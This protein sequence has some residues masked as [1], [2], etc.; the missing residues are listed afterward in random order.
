MVRTRRALETRRLAIIVRY[1]T[2]KILIGFKMTYL[3]DSLFTE[4]KSSSD[5]EAANVRLSHGCFLVECSDDEAVSS[6]KMTFLGK[7]SHFVSQPSR[8][9]TTPLICDGALR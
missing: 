9:P 5:E 7:S 3:K 2:Q 6:I 8:L 4:K 1:C